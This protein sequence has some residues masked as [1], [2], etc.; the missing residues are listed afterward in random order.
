MPRPPDSATLDRLKNLVG[1]PGLVPDAADVAPYLREWRNRWVGET[2]LLL[3]PGTTDEVA[4]IMRVCHAANVG[5]VPQ[6]GNTGLVGGQIPRV[7]HGE[8]LLSLRRLD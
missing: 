7:G 6:G 8:I 3:C 5:V 2:P 1:A 4:A